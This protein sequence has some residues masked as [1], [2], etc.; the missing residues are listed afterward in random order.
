M[1]YCPFVLSQT[2]NLEALYRPLANRILTA[3]HSRP[4]FY[5]RRAPLTLV[6]YSLLLRNSKPLL[7]PS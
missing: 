5:H 1:T 6:P 3:L 7:A 4:R 2:L